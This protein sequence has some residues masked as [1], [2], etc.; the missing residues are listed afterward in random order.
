MS[1]SSSHATVTY[2]S[3]SI[4]NDLPPWGF[5]LIKPEAPE[6]PPQSPEEAPPS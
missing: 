5:H 2:T 3:V 6:S 1:S 4:D